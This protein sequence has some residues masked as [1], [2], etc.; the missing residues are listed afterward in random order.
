MLRRTLAVALAAIALGGSA[1]AITIGLALYF[2]L[3]ATAPADL[4]IVQAGQPDV[5]VRG[6]TFTTEPFRNPLYYGARLWAGESTGWRF[7]IE[8]THQKLYYRGAT[9]G[10]E[11]INRLTVT[12]GL[13]LLTVNAAYHWPLGD[14]PRGGLRAGAGI[15][16]PHPESSIRGREWGV[17]NDPAY[18]H[19]GGFSARAGVA[20]ELGNPSLYATLEGQATFTSGFLLIG[21]G[22]IDAS[23]LTGH[24]IAGPGFTLR[25]P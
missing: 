1:Q 9:S 25:L 4:T 3:S 21:D 16:I 24:L 23:F 18:Y 15:V 10:G 17:D 19:L 14:G 12:D 5:T 20:L 6:A 2:G 7:E 8:F 13:N 22:R 11:A